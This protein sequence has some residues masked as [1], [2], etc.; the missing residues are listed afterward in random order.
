M[1]EHAGATAP[2]AILPK[3][4]EAADNPGGWDWLALD[5]DW[6]RLAL[7][8]TRAPAEARGGVKFRPDRPRDDCGGRMLGCIRLNDPD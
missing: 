4:R 8:L 2:A 7:D 5:V 1:I 3:E 6:D